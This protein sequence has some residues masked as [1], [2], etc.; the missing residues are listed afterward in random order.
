MKYLGKICVFLMAMGISSAPAY[1]PTT[2][3][4]GVPNNIYSPL[5]V[6]NA[7]QDIDTYL[8][9][10]F[11]PQVNLLALAQNSQHLSGQCQS[12]GLGFQ[13][14]LYMDKVLRGLYSQIYAAALINH[15][16][17]HDQSFNVKHDTSASIADTHLAIGWKALHNKKVTLSGYL[18]GIIPATKQALFDSNKTIDWIGLDN[19]FAWGTGLDLFVRIWGNQRHHIDWLTDTNVTFLTSRNAQAW[20]NDNGYKLYPIKIHAHQLYKCQTSL[21]YQFKNFISDCG[22]SYFYMPGPQYDMNGI[23]KRLNPSDLWVSFL[24]DIGTILPLH[25]SH[26]YCSL[27]AQVTYYNHSF[28]MWSA[29]LKCGLRF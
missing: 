20:K 7:S 16:R 26:F 18:F 28:D 9:F 14:T 4:R 21:A 25:R 19:H 1:V 15:G 2:W 3:I 27:G 5:A 17:T 10:N 24:G 13:G 8:P 22:M 11:D 12:Y 29:N 6:I 23:T